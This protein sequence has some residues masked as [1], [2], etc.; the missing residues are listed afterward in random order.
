MLSGQTLFKTELY[1]QS[2]FLNL[3]FVTMGIEPRALSTF[4]MCS[5]IELNLLPVMT[6]FFFTGPRTSLWEE[7]T[8]PGFTDYHV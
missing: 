6:I 4:G 2:F 8:Q 3:N 7:K 1:F 5:F